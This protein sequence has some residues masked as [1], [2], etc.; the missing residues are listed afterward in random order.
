M[1]II[2]VHVCIMYIY[3]IYTSNKRRQKGLLQ[4]P[5]SGVAMLPPQW[6]WEE[7]PCCPVCVPVALPLACTQL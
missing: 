4:M 5:F 2:W 6:P 3:N 1:H 7:G